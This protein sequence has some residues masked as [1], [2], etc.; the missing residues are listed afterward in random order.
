[1]GALLIPTWLRDAS[2]QIS[3]RDEAS[4]SEVREAVRELGAAAGL[5]TLAIERTTSAVSEL[6]RNQLVHAH[7]GIVG[8]RSLARGDIPGIEVIAVDAGP[9]IADPASAYRGGRSSGS[10][11]VGLAAAH[12]QVHELDADVRLGQGTCIRVRTFA[13]PVARCEV[14]IFGQPHPDEPVSGDHAGA[15]R[16]SDG[17]TIGIADGLGHGPL[18]REPAERAISELMRFADD[19]PDR[20]LDHCHAALR[21]TRGVVMASA[22]ISAGRAVT[23]ASVGNIMAR[24]I[25]PGAMQLLP[26]AP[27]VLGTNAY[28]RR[29]PLERFTLSPHQVF[30]LCTDGI[31]TRFEI[32]EP[33]LLREPALVIAQHVVERFARPTDDALVLVVR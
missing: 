27:G 17:C 25:G 8:L 26:S 33:S 1:V 15:S 2:T 29:V 4:V 6:A 5:E 10:L 11:G 14:A 22:K 7:G 23:Y 28:P 24:V 19:R 13:R 16:T 30:V 20:I 32:D 18:A 9:G 21:G 31:A 12:R 3:V